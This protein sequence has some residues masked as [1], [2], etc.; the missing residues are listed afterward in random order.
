MLKLVTWVDK[1]TESAIKPVK[2]GYKL[3]KNVR[4]H[5]K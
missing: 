2:L 1:Q 3:V 5:I 4:G